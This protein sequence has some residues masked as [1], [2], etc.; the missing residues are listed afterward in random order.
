MFSPY[1]TPN[2]YKVSRGNS[3]F[4]LGFINLQRKWR[5]NRI[6]EL[7]G[8]SAHI[9]AAKGSDSD[10]ERYCS[11]G[12]DV[13]SFGEP[14]KQGERTDLKRVVSTVEQSTSLSEVIAAHPEAYIRYHRGIE[15]LFC[16]TGKSVVRQWKSQSIVFYGESGSGKSRAAAELTNQKA[17]YKTRGEWWDLY[18]GQEDVI[19]DDFYGWIKLDEF[20]RVTDRYPLQVPIKGGFVQFIAKRIIFTSNKEPLEWYSSDVLSGELKKAFIRRLDKIFYCTK[21]SFTIIKLD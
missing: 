15:K 3:C 18:Q 11:K 14:L 21:E 5:F 7:V 12:G 17:Y 20:L 10:N 1:L 13:W 4:L 19:F 2:L 9:E 8:A 6:K 16:A